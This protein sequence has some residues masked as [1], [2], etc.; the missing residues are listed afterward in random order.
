MRHKLTHVEEGEFSCMECGKQFRLLSALN[1]HLKFHAR[2][3]IIS[4]LN[5]NNENF[6]KSGQPSHLNV[7][8]CTSLSNNKPTVKL[9]SVRLFSNKNKEVQIKTENAVDLK[10]DVNEL[11][12]MNLSDVLDFSR[13]EGKSHRQKFDPCQ[14]VQREPG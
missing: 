6:N 9:A 12:E 2:E 10:P 4:E 11:M 7:N 14:S 5:D 1:K 8:N 3:S 13:D